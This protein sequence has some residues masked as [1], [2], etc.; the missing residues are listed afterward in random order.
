L[1]SR[2]STRPRSDLAAEFELEDENAARV[3]RVVPQSPADETGV[4]PGDV[5]VEVD[6]SGVPGSKTLREKLADADSSVLMLIRRDDATIF[7]PMKRAGWRAS[8]LRCNIGWESHP[9]SPIRRCAR[10]E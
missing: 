9:P 5:I 10:V 7:I 4:E 6:R 3:S 1:R 8:S 2:G